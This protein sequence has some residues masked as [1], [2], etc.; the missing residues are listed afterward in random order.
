MPP[1]HWDMRRGLYFVLMVVLVLRGLTGTAMAA[2]VLPPLLPASAPHAQEHSHV[3][4]AEAAYPTSQEHRTDQAAQAMAAEMQ[5]G[6][7]AIAHHDDHAVH[8]AAASAC[9]G[10]L[11]GC[12]AHD[13]HS[14]A[15]SACEI[16]HSAMLDAAPA[17]SCALR[18][19]G[20]PLPTASARFDSA[21]P[22]LTIK[23]PIA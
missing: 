12:A 4:A 17:A 8:A 21:P 13:H 11:V 22:A 6:D 7:H 2:G 23:P 19:P 1:Y 20:T 3:V 9:D 5:E 16:C 14:A 18:R 15:C 10:E